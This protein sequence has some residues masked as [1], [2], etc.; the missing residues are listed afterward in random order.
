MGMKYFKDRHQVNPKER[1]NYRAI[2]TAIEE[3][4]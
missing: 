1:R 3:M 2:Y 4:N